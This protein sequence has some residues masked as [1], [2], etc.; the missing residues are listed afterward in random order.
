MK[1]NKIFLF[2]AMALTSLSLASC[3]DDDDFTPGK[4]AGSNDV[5]FTNQGNQTVSLE[6]TSFTITLGRSNASGALSVPLKQIQVSPMLTV[7]ATAE[8]AAGETETEVTIQVNSE[9]KP[10]TDLHLRLSIPEEYT[11][12]YKAPTNGVPELNINIQKEDY[13]PFKTGTYF[14]EFWETEEEDIVLEYSPMLDTYRFQ[15]VAMD[16]TFTFK[17]DE[18]GNISVLQSAFATAYVHPDYGVISANRSSD[19]PSFVDVDEDGVTTYVFCFEYT[20]SAGSFGSAL[21]YFV[22]NP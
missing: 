13:A 22:V 11:S 19:A 21:D 16:E 14:S 12:P 4:A 7:P 3:S 20:V 2:A 15:H 10:F 1:I 5:Y 8:F 17:V 18:E 6:A 9:A